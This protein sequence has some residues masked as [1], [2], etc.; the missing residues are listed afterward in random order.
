MYEALNKEPIQ[1]LEGTVE[2]YPSLPPFFTNKLKA[3]DFTNPHNV[4]NELALNIM[5]ISLMEIMDNDPDGL[6]L[7]QSMNGLARLL[8]L[9]G[10]TA[11]TQTLNMDIYQQEGLTKA[12]ARYCKPESTSPQI[13]PE[14]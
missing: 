7:V 4:A 14:P 12:V 8:R 9:A 10:V 3:G 6:E 1:I 11:A 13:L 2:T 5:G